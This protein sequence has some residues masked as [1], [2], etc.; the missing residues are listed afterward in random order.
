MTDSQV[1]KLLLLSV[2]CVIRW[3]TIDAAK[4]KGQI[5]TVSKRNENQNNF[6]LVRN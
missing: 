2:L 1:I 4:F 6:F 3:N 5:R